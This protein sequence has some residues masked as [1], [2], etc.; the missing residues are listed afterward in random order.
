MLFSLSGLNALLP[1]L[2]YP[3]G[4]V[5]LY[6]VI[7]E[8]W[9]YCLYPP[10]LW[11]VRRRFGWFCVLAVAL[12]LSIMSMAPF[13]LGRL[14]G[15]ARSVTCEFLFLWWAGAFAAEC[16]S[17]NIFVGKYVRPIWIGAVIVY[18]IINYFAHFQLLWAFSGPSFGVLCAVFLFAIDSIFSG[19]SIFSRCFGWIGIRSYSLYAIHWPIMGF[20][21][22]ILTR[23]G[24][25]APYIL[26]LFPLLM[27]AAVTILAYEC[28]EKPSQA[29]ARKL[30]SRGT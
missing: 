11:I 22:W 26:W 12:C 29:W 19:K 18:L 16:Y 21:Y 27:V 13:S 8:M 20:S 4:N 17:R 28:V 5:V 24:N 7:A 6:T 30:A 1:G 2:D 14:F 3:I 15:W 9:L 25:S 23:W 10:I